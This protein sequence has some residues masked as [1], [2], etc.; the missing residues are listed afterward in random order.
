M[1]FIQSYMLKTL[2]IEI[3]IIINFCVCEWKW[4]G[5]LIWFSYVYFLVGDFNLLW[6]KYLLFH[7][8]H[9]MCDTR[10]GGRSNF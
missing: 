4:K 10:G 2:K 5:F 8:E 6:I 7:V 3:I 1:A 9:A